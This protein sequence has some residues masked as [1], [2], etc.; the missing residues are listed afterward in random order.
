MRG[1][2]VSTEDLFSTLKDQLG[3]QPTTQEYQSWRE[4]VQ[5]D[6]QDWL[7]DNIR[8]FRETDAHSRMMK[9]AV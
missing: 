3:R 4:Y 2:Y 5:S 9:D 6:I 8:A 7:R 1:I